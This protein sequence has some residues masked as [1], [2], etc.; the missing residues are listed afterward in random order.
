LILAGGR[1]E[2]CENRNARSDEKAKQ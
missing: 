1:G 2:T